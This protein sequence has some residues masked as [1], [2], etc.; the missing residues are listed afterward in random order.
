MIAIDLIGQTREYGATL[1]LE[2]D[3][4]LL[5]DASQVPES[6]LERLRRH[7]AA[8]EAQLRKD[9]QSQACISK[10]APPAALNHGR[11]QPDHRSHAASSHLPH[12]RKL[13]I[14]VILTSARKLEVKASSSMKKSFA[15]DAMNYVRRHR[16]EIIEEIR[17]QAQP[18]VD[19]L[20]RQLIGKEAIP[21]NLPFLET[22]ESEAKERLNGYPFFLA[23]FLT[24][25]TKLKNLVQRSQNR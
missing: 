25:T 20:V 14:S 15:R 10:E 9:L 21:E 13:G 18:V 7:K 19:D 12:L 6:L 22:L 5:L 23:D 16:A 17:S 4:V 1:A 3:K 2:G 11:P 24:Q 8:I